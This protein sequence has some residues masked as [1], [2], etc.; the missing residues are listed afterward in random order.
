[1]RV[2]IDCRYLRER[3]SG[4]GAYVETL[5][6]QLPWLAPEDEFDFWAHRLARSPLSDA[7]NVHEDRVK[8]EPNS[9]WTTFW[10]QRFADLS[11]TDL[12]HSPH[13]ILPRNIPCPTVVTVHDLLPLE[14]PA[15]A[16]IPLTQRLK[17]WYYVDAVCRGLR[18]ARAIITTTT[19]MADRLNHFASGASRRARVIPMGV[20]EEFR[21]P[22]DT[23]LSRERSAHLI[24]DDRP[25]FLVVGQNAPHK[26]HI[27]AL[28]AFGQAAPDN[29]RLV[30]VQRQTARAPLADFARDL[31]LTDRVHWFPHLE[32]DDLIALYQNAFALI[33]PSLY[34][35]F[36]LPLLEAMACGCPVIATDIPVF[37]EVV[38]T[39]GLF[40]SADDVASFAAAMRSL[41]ESAHR[42]GELRDAGI[43]RAAQFTWDKCV[44]RTLDVYREIAGVAL[45][46]QTIRSSPPLVL[47]SRVKNLSS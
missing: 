2:A 13:N 44:G 42:S 6:D 32:T 23:N 17:R 31:G 14:H 11:Q 28:K 5:V 38:R 3:P 33:Q 47:A 34:D 4:I 37:R 36:G 35:G 20:G 29:F 40:A 7:P 19:A 8:A 16:F 21:R 45:R 41:I 27:I 10:P 12:F 26:R 18:K 9:L 25:F 39:A 46:F 15:L 43:E 24:G 1:M 22:N 30:F